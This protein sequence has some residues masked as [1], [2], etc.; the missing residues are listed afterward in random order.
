MASACHLALVSMVMPHYPELPDV[1]Q[2]LS[3]VAQALVLTP[4]QYKHTHVPKGKPLGAGT[5]AQCR[6]LALNGSGLEF[7]SAPPNQIIK[8]K[9]YGKQG[10]S[11]VR[12]PGCS[13]KGPRFNSQH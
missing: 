13:Y 12:S 11:V 5:V 8:K 6:A 9:E 1:R 3:L 7:A 4:Q 10:G 2:S